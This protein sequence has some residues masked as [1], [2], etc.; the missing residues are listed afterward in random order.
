MSVGIDGCFQ[1]LKQEFEKEGMKTLVHDFLKKARYSPKWMLYSDYCLDDKNKPNDVLTFVLIPFISEDKYLELEQRIKETQPVDIKHTNNISE[2]FMSYIKTQAVFSFSFI[3]NDRQKLFGA[4]EKEQIKT[5]EQTLI[6]LKNAY[7]RWRDNAVNK[8]QEER[9]KDYISKI[10]SQLRDI[11]LKKKVKD[12]IDVLLITMLAAYYT[13]SILKLLPDLQLF[14]WFPDRDKT[15]ET[16]GQ[17]AVPIFNT[18]QYEFLGANQYQ[19]CAAKPDSSVVPYY[20]NENRIADIICGTL[21]DHNIKENLISKDKFDTV[22]QGLMADNM[23]VKV[24]RFFIDE[25]GTH[26]GELKISKLPLK[27]KEDKSKES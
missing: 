11:F 23:Y 1:L 13:A 27:E 5:I 26:M 10:N 19:F 9:Y 6:N 2:E 12:Q 8:E 14:G 4:N 18:Y 20:D 7:T 3:V 17:M 15:N 25:A 16:C 22:L 24:Y 21:A